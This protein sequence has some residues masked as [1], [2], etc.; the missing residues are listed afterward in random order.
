[1]KRLR[2]V[3]QVSIIQIEKPGEIE[4]ILPLGKIFRKQSML[5]QGN[6]YAKGIAQ[7]ITIESLLRKKGP[8]RKRQ[9]NSEIL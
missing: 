9:R 4:K 1:M 7:Q 5:R 3:I 6:Y 2:I 8:I